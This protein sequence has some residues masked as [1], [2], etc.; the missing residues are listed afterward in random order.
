MD[1]RSAL[2][3]TVGGVLMTGGV[4]LGQEGSDAGDLEVTIALITDPEAEAP[5]AV[6]NEIVIPGPNEPEDSKSSDA[7]STHRAEGQ[8][9]A[10]ANQAEAL[11]KAEAARSEAESNRESFAHGDHELPDRVPEIPGP[12]ETP[13][14]P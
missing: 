5:D 13:A 2:I 7:G 1:V 3:T 12:P 14:P 4:A 6:L 9:K 11:A 8:A 10:L